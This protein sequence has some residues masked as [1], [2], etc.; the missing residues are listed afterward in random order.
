[1]PDV[2]LNEIAAETYKKVIPYNTVY[3]GK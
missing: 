1:L 3:R 2:D